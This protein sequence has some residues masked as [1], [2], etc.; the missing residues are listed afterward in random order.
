MKNAPPVYDKDGVHILDPADKLGHKSKYI[1]VLQNIAL[2]KIIP[3]PYGER[4]AIDLGCG[5]GRLTDILAKKGWEVIGIDPDDSQINYAKDNFS[6]LEFRVGGLPD[7]P[8][9]KSS[10][11]LILLNNVLRTLLLLKSEDWASTIHEYLKP[12]GKLIVVENAKL[13]SDQHFDSPTLIHFFEKQGLHYVGKTNFRASRN[14]LLVP[15][16]YGLLPEG[17]FEPLAK[18][19]VAILNSISSDPRLQYYNTAYTFSNS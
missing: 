3:A 12:A 6:D 9:D 11:D 8:V 4:R 5:W 19:E 16:K 15:I 10:Q 1:T 7:I 14:P 17:I 2:N 18:L 13:N